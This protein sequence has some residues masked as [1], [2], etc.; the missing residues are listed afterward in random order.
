MAYEK[1]EMQFNSGDKVAQ[2]LLFSYIKGKAAPVE[3][4]GGFG[5]TGKRVFS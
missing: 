2:L 3:K 1:R 4:N 5:S